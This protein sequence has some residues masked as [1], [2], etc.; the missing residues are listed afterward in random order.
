MLTFLK[1]SNVLN[2]LKCAFVV[3][4]L[5]VLHWVVKNLLHQN[6]DGIKI[7]GGI[8]SMILSSLKG[9]SPRDQTRSVHRFWGNE[10]MKLPSHY[11]SYLKG[12]SSVV[13]SHWLE[14]G[15]HNPSFQ[16]GKKRRSRN[17]EASQSYLYA[18][19][20]SWGRSS[21]NPY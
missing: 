19:A 6:T 2:A 13:K 5:T 12:H 20:R 10:Q 1:V 8:V 18:F 9:I 14:K 4:S 11:P 15:K 16:E 3:T 7:E 17:L 21:W